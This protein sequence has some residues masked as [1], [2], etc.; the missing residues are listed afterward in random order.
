MKKKVHAGYN[1]DTIHNAHDED[2]DILRALDRY[3]V[4]NSESE[5][6]KD[7]KE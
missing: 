7:K 6:E 2:D 1:T 3:F 4:Y 5:D